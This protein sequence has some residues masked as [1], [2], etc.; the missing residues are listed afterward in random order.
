MNIYE[1]KM[2]KLVLILS[3]I[4]ISHFIKLS[5]N[6]QIILVLGCSNVNIQNQ[7]IES[8]F[9]Y[10]NNQN[11]PV[12]LYLSGGRKT[13]EMIESEADIMLRQIKQKFPDIEIH[14]DRT[15]T[16]TVENFINF[17]KWLHEEKLDYNQII[18]NTSDFHKERAEKIFYRVIDNIKPNWNLSISQCKW[19]WESETQHMKNVESDIKNAL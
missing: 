19:C 16:N 11:Q 18:I 3:S 1:L 7:R 8:L 12:I 2:I 15:A 4:W 10:I 6:P 5:T 17:Y 9:E 13:P 14:I